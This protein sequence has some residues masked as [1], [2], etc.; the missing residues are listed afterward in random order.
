MTIQGCEIVYDGCPKTFDVIWW[1]QT[2]FE[3]TAVQACPRG[4]SGQASRQCFKDVG[5][6]APD[7]FNCVSDTFAELRDLLSRLQTGD[8]EVTTYLAIK[9]RGMLDGLWVSRFSLERNVSFAIK[10]ILSG[11]TKPN[12]V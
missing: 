1:E 9:V 7:T 12:K 4:A 2:P 10:F 8:L 11:S 5:W 3:G 6:G